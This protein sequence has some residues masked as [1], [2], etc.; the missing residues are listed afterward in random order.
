MHQIAT[1][2]QDGFPSCIRPAA[3]MERCDTWEHLCNGNK[4]QCPSPRDDLWLSSIFVMGKFITLLEPEFSCSS[5]YLIYFQIT[6]LLRWLFLKCFPLLSSTHKNRICPFTQNMG[7]AKGRQRFLALA[8][9]EMFT[10]PMTQSTV[11]GLILAQLL[12]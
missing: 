9:P 10:K 3:V 2:F 1:D 12:P 8:H 4:K 6:E 11:W 7:L 5:R